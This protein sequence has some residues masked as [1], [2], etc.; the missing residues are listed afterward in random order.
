MDFAHYLV[1]LKL[2][3]SIK[4]ITNCTLYCRV[5]IGL[6][7][8]VCIMKISFESL[9]Q[10]DSIHQDLLFYPEDGNITCARN[11]RFIYY[12]FLSILKPSHD[13]HHTK[14]LRLIILNGVKYSFEV[15]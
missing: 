6:T 12:L 9:R 14:F 13:G 8:R 4:Q 3:R 5:K 1:F 2:T 11:V 15:S 7:F 10:R